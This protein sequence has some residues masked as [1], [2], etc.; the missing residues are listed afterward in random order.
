MKRDRDSEFCDYRKET[1]W[2]SRSSASRSRRKLFFHAGT[3]P[4]RWEAFFVFT[5]NRLLARSLARS[6]ARLRFSSAISCRV[7]YRAKR[8]R[9]WRMQC[10]A[11]V[12]A[13]W[14]LETSWNSIN[15]QNTELLQNFPERY[16]SIH[17]RYI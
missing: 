6:F 4:G 10:D 2:D 13:H 5:R 16:Q 1:M 11:T 12:D 14:K 7:F 17:R 3:Y 9:S 15:A 8:G